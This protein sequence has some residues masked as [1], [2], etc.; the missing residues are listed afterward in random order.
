MKVY[1]EQVPQTT[2]FLRLK[3]RE[4][5]GQELSM[6]KIRSRFKLTELQKHLP[7]HTLK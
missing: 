2:S 6:I 3:E 1:S 7:V 4:L 5:S